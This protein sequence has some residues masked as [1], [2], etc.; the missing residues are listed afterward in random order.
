MMK[1]GRKKLV[2][3]KESQ[4]ENIGNIPCAVITMRGVMRVPV[5]LQNF[6]CKLYKCL[7]AMCNLGTCPDGNQ[8][9]K[10]KSIG[11]RSIQ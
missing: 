8:T 9:W 1:G 6:F 5:L 2:V 10:L 7:T 11:Q 4:N 3:T